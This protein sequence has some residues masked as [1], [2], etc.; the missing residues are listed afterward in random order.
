[1]SH[2]RIYMVKPSGLNGIAF[3][4][5]KFYQPRIAIA[6]SLILSGAAIDLSKDTRDIKEILKER[7]GKKEAD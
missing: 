4:E 5:G 6:N 2:K 7:K 1:M 3:C